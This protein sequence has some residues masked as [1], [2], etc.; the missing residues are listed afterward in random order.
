MYRATTLIGLARNRLRADGALD[1]EGERWL[2]T[3]E[4]LCATHGINSWTKRTKALRAE[5]AT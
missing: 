1:D 3:A 4:D 2:T 5:L